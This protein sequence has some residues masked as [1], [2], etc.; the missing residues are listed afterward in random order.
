LSAVPG[1]GAGAGGGATQGADDGFDSLFAFLPIGAY[2]SS[3]DGRQL[4]ANPALVRLNGYASE[5]EQLAG[6]RD[7]AREWY[8]D[9]TR[10]DAFKRLLEGQGRV[11]GF[12]SEIHRHKTRERIWISENAHVVRDAAG[13]VRYY[14]GTVEDITARKQAEAALLR[15]EQTLRETAARLPGVVFRVLHFDDGRRH[16]DYISEGVTALCGLTPQQLREDGEAFARLRHPEDRARLDEAIRAATACDGDLSIEYRL[17]PPDGRVK[18]VQHRSSG[19]PREGG[20]HVRV[21]VIL[22]VTARREAELALL[23]TS[24]LWKLALESTGD[25]VW[26][27][28]LATGEELLSPQCL[29]MYGFAPGELPP[30]ADA[31]DGR[32]HPD[33]VPAMQAARDAHLAGR[34]P[35]YVN[36]HRVRCKDGRWKWV[37]SRGMVIERAPDGRPLRMVG[38]HT[39]IDERKQAEALRAQRDAAA[40]AD[41]AKTLFLSRVS[42]ELRTPLNAILGFAQLLELQQGRPPDAE[43]AQREQGWVRQILTSGRHLLAL[44]DDILDLSSAQT[45]QMAL[46][47]QPVEP[48]AVVQ[49]ACA[50]LAA[51]AREAGVELHDAVAGTPLPPLRADRRRLTQVLSNLL[52]NAVKYNRRG[53]W[54]RVQAGR[55]DDGRVELA[56]A[57]SGAGLTPAQLARLFQPFERLGAQSGPVP[58]SGLGLALSR[59][60]VLAMGGEIGADSR[61]GEGSRFWVRLP[62]A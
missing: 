37:L 55:L 28:N 43:A 40:A 51:A 11:I 32:T 62:A 59:Q 10:R 48:A 25:G 36:E 17:C 6:V 52:S 44:M 2:R 16:V 42:H 58:G 31:L 3:P 30:D 38:T 29:A 47:L 21:G 33:D 53:G 50:M 49:Q 27:W 14:E 23:R 34:S 4:R 5:A 56:V 35:S 8:V 60:L 22:D 54:V 26:D 7:I 15:S 61:V 20:A 46:A 9:P 24:Q 13:A 41:R 57:D 39:D 18:W 19:G 45:G 12:E 1:P